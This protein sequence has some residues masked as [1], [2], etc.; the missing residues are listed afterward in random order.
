[1]KAWEMFTEPVGDAASV[2]GKPA[3]WSG[4]NPGRVMLTREVAQELES[5]CQQDGT[6]NAQRQHWM[7]RWQGII[8][9]IH[10]PISIHDAC[11]HPF[12]VN[13]AFSRRIARPLP[14]LPELLLA[15]RD[16]FDWQEEISFQSPDGQHQHLRLMV[17]LITGPN[18]Q[19]LGF[20]CSYFDLSDM[21]TARQQILER[22]GQLQAI[23]H[24][25]QDAI[26]VLDSGGKILLWNPAAQGIFG[27]TETE[28][29]GLDL[30]GLLAPPEQAAGS[31][32]GLEHF[33]TTG[34]GP[35]VGQVVELEAVHK[36]G[37]RVPIE[38]SVSGFRHR[39]AWYSVGIA[40]DI[41]ER[42]RN[43]RDLIV[44]L[45]GYQLLSRCNQVLIHARD[46]EALLSEMCHA[47]TQVGAY[48][49]AWI[50]MLEQEP[51]QL[52]RPVAVSGPEGE[53][54]FHSV[55]RWDASPL[56][57]GVSG[58]AARTGQIQCVSDS[59]EDARSAPW[60]EL[61]DRLGIK[62][63]IALPLKL[64]TGTTFG[65]LTILTERPDAFSADEIGLLE[66]L[67]DDLSFGL[68]NLQALDERDYYQQ[69]HLRTVENLKESLI[70][71]I[72]AFSMALE[73][74]DPYTAGHQNR[75]AELAA[76]IAGEMGLPEDRIEGIR[77]GAMIHDI[78][79]IS[80]P[81]EILNR[82]G[83]LTPA[84]FEIIKSHPQTGY[85]IV[86][87]IQFPWPV[88]DMILQHHER[89]DGS[90]YP[91]GLNADEII[92]EARILAVADVVEAINAH[93]PYR[94]AIGLDTALEEIESNRGRYY[95]P[96]VVDA[97][98]RLFREKGYQ[99]PCQ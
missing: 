83:K 69:E 39:G 37:H 80:V 49:L 44:A 35:I 33:R 88:A 21:D 30:H 97:C 70:G 4:E 8:D 38:L 79:K 58:R 75:V 67:A 29:A 26:I 40:R 61:L 63:S 95:D 2:E 42:K 19:S 23:N 72:K 68:H 86:S 85:D 59:L 60:L 10:T 32:K 27:Y 11:G 22:E 51:E 89:M 74:R 9:A 24:A 20:I 87:D 3:S 53:A 43:A 28:V 66:E 93:R 17:S 45:R 56:G 5:L 6:E 12:L 64:P 62:S 99:L 57:Q 7:S 13:Q 98:L 18:E 78:G 50:G 71:T 90:G 73:K 65:V 36:S 96:V 46:R 84:E 76:A 55:F 48:A 14:Q 54:I 41:S 25:A 77:L 52:I 81:A 16:C 91:L 1:M 82:P 31:Q 47:I 94:P 34:D 15:G 92:L